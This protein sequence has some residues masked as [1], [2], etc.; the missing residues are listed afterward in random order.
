MIPST[1]WQEAL[2]ELLRALGETAWMVGWSF[3]ITAIL[4]IAIGVLLRLWAPDGLAPNRFLYF[5]VGAVV[6]IVLDPIFIFGYCG[7]ALSGT[8]G[9]A[10]ATVIGQFCGAGMALYFLGGWIRSSLVAASIAGVAVV[11]IRIASYPWYLGVAP[12]L[13]GYVLLVLGGRLPVRLGARNDISYGVYIY[14]F[15]VQQMLALSGGHALG[16]LG[17]AAVSTALTVPLAWVS[18]K[19]VEEPA[20]KLRRLVPAHLFKRKY[21]PRRSE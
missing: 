7:E 13:L 15:P 2:P 17:F 8:T 3:L 14:A 11:A 1:S 4:G 10:V 9:A 16:V 20:M 19:L 6:N 21:V 12:L 18:W 5:A